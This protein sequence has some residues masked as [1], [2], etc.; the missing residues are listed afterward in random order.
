VSFKEEKRLADSSFKLKTRAIYKRNRI[1][2]VKTPMTKGSLIRKDPS[3]LPFPIAAAAPTLKKT[4][5][6]A[7]RPLPQS[8]AHLLASCS[9][10]Y[11][12]TLG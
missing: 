9:P 8:M 7:P 11:P 1:R 2:T 10:S 12:K 3:A 6:L 4:A 5:K